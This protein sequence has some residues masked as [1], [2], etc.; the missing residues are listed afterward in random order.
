MMQFL[1][2]LFFIHSFSKWKKEPG[3]H[4]IRQSVIAGINIAL[5][6]LASVQ[7]LL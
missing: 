6:T 1:L 5:K 2:L 4:L 7:H 3:D